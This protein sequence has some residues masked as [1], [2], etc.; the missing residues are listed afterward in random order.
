MHLRATK[1]GIT[2]QLPDCVGQ[3]AVAAR[4]VFLG[5]DWTTSSY[6]ILR[7][8]SLNNSNIQKAAG[9]RT[10]GLIC[11]IGQARP[12]WRRRPELRHDINRRNF[13]E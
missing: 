3:T 10:V 8:T 7:I 5:L 9:A 6:S 13:V 2:R 4:D 12:D 1:K 11:Q